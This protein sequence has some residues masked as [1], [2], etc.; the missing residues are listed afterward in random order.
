MLRDV[1]LAIH[2]GGNRVL[3]TAAILLTSSPLAARERTPP[4][5]SDLVEALVRCR[6][7]GGGSE[8]LRCFDQ[9]ASSL[10][11]AVRNR[12]VVVVDREKVEAAER[13]KFGE[14]RRTHDLP[15]LEA[16][17]GSKLKSL[18]GIVRAASDAGDGN[19]T[20]ILQDGSVWRQTDGVPLALPPRAGD[21]VVIV[22]A[23][24]GTFKMRVRGQPAVRV[25]RL[26]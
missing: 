26:G 6:A 21:P 8:R 3:C 24:M 15:T 23:S 25:R 2:R 7:I 19:W 22:R 14:R 5:T 20:M 13:A 11:T 9:A 12:S 17:D 4:P 10:E 18:D 16:S 1:A